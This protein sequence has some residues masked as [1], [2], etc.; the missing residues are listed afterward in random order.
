M[1]LKFEPMPDLIRNYD[2]AGVKYEILGDPTQHK[3][4][5]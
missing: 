3:V 5:Y 1:K 2:I 4:R